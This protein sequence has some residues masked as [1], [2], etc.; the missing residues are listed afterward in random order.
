LP[1]I[2]T[3]TWFPPKVNFA[4]LYYVRQVR[5]V[6][7]S[8]LT[9]AIFHIALFFTLWIVG[10]FGTKGGMIVRAFPA[11][12]PGAVTPYE[13][14][15][16][17]E[18]KISK[19]FR[20]DFISTLD[21]RRVK[22]VEPKEEPPPPPEP[23]EPEEPKAEPTLPAPPPEE[24]APPVYIR[25]G[26]KTTSAKDES[27]K[28]IVFPDIELTDVFGQPFS[29]WRLFGPFEQGG[30]T[31]VIV[32]CDVSREEG[33]ND[34]TL[35]ADMWVKFLGIRGLGELPHVLC[36]GNIVDNPYVH[37]V[38]YYEQAL[39]MVF[40]DYREQI[41]Y[42]TQSFQVTGVIDVHGEILRA[43]SDEL[44]ENVT[45][46]TKPMLMLVDNW[47]VIR[48]MMWGRPV[49]IS[50]EEVDQAGGIIREIWTM[51]DLEYTLFKGMILTMQAN[52]K[53]KEGIK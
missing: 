27:A 51:T 45:D 4:G 52:E 28:Y 47:G 9:S 49:D 2:A 24:Q 15:K 14:K 30:R 29:A 32:F 10:L 41:Q 12:P 18:E 46:L 36:I 38:E 20:V 44:G 48:I 16:T 33:Y 11:A 43:V 42:Y 26:I 25:P 35:W 7:W 23:K 34:L 1:E 5:I 8:Y 50:A 40:A 21:S 19:F 31:A 6:A 53:A 13:K 3:S 17:D 22:W 37:P 39:K